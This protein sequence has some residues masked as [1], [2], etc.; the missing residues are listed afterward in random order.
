M[1]GNA[2]AAMAMKRARAKKAKEEAAKGPKQPVV[3]EGTFCAPCPR[4]HACAVP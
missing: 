2:A 4:S 3:E 1:P